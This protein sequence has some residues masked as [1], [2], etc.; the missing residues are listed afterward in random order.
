MHGCSGL[1][2][3]L[4]ASASLAEPLT[5][6]RTMPLTGLGGVSAIEVEDAGRTALVLSDRGAGYRFD[7]LRDGQTARIANV[8][9]VM[10]PFP[11]R[12]TEGLAVADGKTFLSYE[13]PAEVSTLSGQVL[14]SPRA[15]HDLPAN[16][17]LE[18]LAIAPDGALYT[19][20]EN[21]RNGGGPIPIYRFQ[22]N[23]WTVVAHLPR[24]EGFAPTGADFGPDGLLY[25]LERSFSALGFRTRI[26][27]VDP[28]GGTLN[29]ETLLTTRL[30]THDKL[31]GLSVWSSDSGAVCLSM[32]SDNNFLS[33]QASELVEYALTETLAGGA[34]CD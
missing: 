3:I 19:L 23:R 24:S 2:L 15:F 10:L 6:L 30:R 1:A 27:R 16:G 20:P 29:P 14:P 9:D 4:S 31:E 7:I 34:R 22:D 33:I 26:R 17:A 5:F 28:M 21:P 32:V 25:I 8:T 13:A 12:D 11:H 18:A